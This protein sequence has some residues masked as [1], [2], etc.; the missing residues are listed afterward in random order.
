MTIVSLVVANLAMAS[1]AVVSLVLCHS[2]RYYVELLGRAI[3]PYYCHGPSNV[4]GRCHS[5]WKSN[6]F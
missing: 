4:D 1:L 6:S 3:Q 5:E 2:H